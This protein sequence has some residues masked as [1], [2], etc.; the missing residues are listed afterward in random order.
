MADTTAPA[1]S[2]PIKITR[3]VCD[4]VAIRGGAI[5]AASKR[6]ESRFEV[7]RLAIEF[8]QPTFQ[9]VLTLEMISVADL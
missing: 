1:G 6:V 8:D 5:A 7:K 3:G 4:Q 2:R 9:W